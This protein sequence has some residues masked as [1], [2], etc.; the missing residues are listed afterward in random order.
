MRKTYII[1][2]AGVNHNGKLDLALKLC[3][4]AKEAGVDAIK[5]QTFKTEKILTKN[6]EMAKYQKETVERKKTQYAMIKELELSYSDFEKIKSY[7]DKIGIEFLST[8]DEEES[9]DFLI[10]MGMGIVKIGS[11]EVNNIPFLRKIGS[12]KKDVILSTGMST[13]DDVE[14]AYFLLSE[15]GAKSVALLHCTTN[16]PCPMDEVNLKAIITLRET[17]KIRIGYSDHTHGIE[18]PIAAVALGSE[19]IE[20]HFTLDK[21]MKG[22]D[23]KSSLSPKELKEMV[24][25]I[26]NIEKAMG[27]GIKRPNKSE[28]EISKV[29]RKSIVASRRIKK[30]ETFS[31]KNITVK[32][33][34]MGMCPTDWDNV[35]GKPA[36]RNYEEDDIIEL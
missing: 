27:N 26:R 4:I 13:I 25:A 9:L 34:G 7:C 11:G 6:T 10:S 16:Y 29:I 33:A 36:K 31:E 32:R 19:I 8:P 14:R 2:E 17:F 24:I 35:I 22:P 23:H 15:T 3:N 12:K 30:W 5:F 18:V 28:I 21:E 1:A 20:K